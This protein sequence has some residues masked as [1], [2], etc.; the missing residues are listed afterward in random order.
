MLY[1]SLYVRGFQVQLSW[2]C[3]GCGVG[4]RMRD[5][6]QPPSPSLSGRKEPTGCLLFSHGGSN[7][8]RAEILGCLALLGITL[9]GTFTHIQGKI[10]VSVKGIRYTADQ[11][12]QEHEITEQRHAAVGQL[13]HYPL[14]FPSAFSSSCTPWHCLQLPA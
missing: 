3:H 7:H 14:P 12:K 9:P 4:Q 1:F 8:G 13:R 2:Q 10:Q 6:Q 11:Q 5:G